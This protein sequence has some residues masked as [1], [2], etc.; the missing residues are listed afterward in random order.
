MFQVGRGLRRVSQIAEKAWS[1]AI[2]EDH[3]GYGVQKL[4][5]SKKLTRNVFVDYFRK[6]FIR[7]VKTRD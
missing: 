5:P 4:M 3:R 6:V 1:V 7:Y 2:G